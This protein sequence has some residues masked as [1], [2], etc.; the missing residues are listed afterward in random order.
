MLHTET[1][2]QIYIQQTCN[3]PEE[4]QDSNTW[5]QTAESPATCFR[6]ERSL[7]LSVL[8]SFLWPVSGYQRWLLQCKSMD[9]AEPFH[10][11]KTWPKRKPE[12]I[13]RSLCL[14][15]LQLYSAVLLLSIYR[16]SGQCALCLVSTDYC[17]EEAGEC[18]R[19]RLLHGYAGAYL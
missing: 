7:Q 5:Q 13:V 11:R 17:H 1:V 16:L 15:A 19:K 2:S 12:G 6:I 9:I 8:E 4:P 14:M 10:A 3:T 18:F